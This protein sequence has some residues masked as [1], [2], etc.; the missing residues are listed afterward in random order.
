MEHEERRILSVGCGVGYIEHIL[1]KSGVD[2]LN[3][4]VSEV[5]DTPLQ[6]LRKEL[7]ENTKKGLT[8]YLQGR[9]RNDIPDL[10]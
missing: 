9:R 2:N 3:L 7:P 8:P 5:V 1:L 6:W 4:D 10:F